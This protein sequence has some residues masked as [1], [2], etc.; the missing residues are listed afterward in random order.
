MDQNQLIIVCYNGGACGDL[1]TALIDSRDSEIDRG[2]VQLDSQRQLLK[3]PHL[4][5]T[6]AEKDHYLSLV[7]QHY[8]SISSHDFEY[9]KKRRHDIV[10]VE[11]DTLEVAVWASTRFKQLHRP[12]VW[13]RMTAACGA[14][15]IQEYAQAMMNFSKMAA[16]YAQYRIKL[17]DIVGGNALLVM[18]SWPNIALDS[19]A[20]E[21]YGNWLK[22]VLPVNLTFARQ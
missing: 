3:N 11:V 7:A 10:T 14:Q 21:T 15:S 4:F 13:N 5:H 8:S 12:H 2:A 19:S 17:S 22:Q 9:H 6:D 20:T 18:Q 1:I 16:D